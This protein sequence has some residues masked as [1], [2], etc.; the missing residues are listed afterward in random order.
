MDQIALVLQGIYPPENTS[1][2]VADRG[3]TVNTT[4]AG[5]YTPFAL[6]NGV[7]PQ[8]PAAQAVSLPSN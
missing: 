6:V 4:T 2:V 3:P 8:S 1:T 5:S 7:A